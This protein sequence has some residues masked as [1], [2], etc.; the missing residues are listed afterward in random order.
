MGVKIEV[1]CGKVAMAH[2]A[3]LE[4]FGGGLQ[5]VGLGVAAWRLLDW[6][7]GA[8]RLLVDVRGGFGFSLFATIPLALE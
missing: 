3:M 4:V 8:R 7:L 2:S 6:F 1:Y 5:Q